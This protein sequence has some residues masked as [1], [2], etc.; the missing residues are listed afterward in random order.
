[1]LISGIVWR[2][3]DNES[4]RAFLIANPDERLD[5]IHEW[6]RYLSPL[7]KLE[8]LCPDA[9]ADAPEN[10]VLLNFASA[11]TTHPCFRTPT[12]ST[13]TGCRFRTWRSNSAGTPAS[14]STSPKT[15]TQGFLEAILKP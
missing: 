12:G 8:R 15:E 4:D 3:V 6:A 14:A 13:S 1:M 9:P 10:R 7:A 5:A 11:T 2:L